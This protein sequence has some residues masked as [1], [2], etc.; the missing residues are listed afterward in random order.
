MKYLGALGIDHDAMSVL[1]YHA[2][3]VLYS[4]AY[5]RQNAIAL[6]QDWP[7]IPP[8]A[9]KTA[10]IRSS[11][12]GE[13]LVALLDEDNSVPN[14]TAGH[15][16]TEISAIAPIFREGCGP[17]NPDAGE[18]DITAGWGHFANSGAVMPGKGKVVEREFSVTERQA[19][20]DGCS[21]FGLSAEQA[22]NLLG[23][24]TFD[25]YL[26]NV[27]YWKNIPSRVWAYTI[28]GYQVI[29]KW[30]SYREREIL[31][32]GLTMEEARVVTD[33]ARRIAAILLMEPALDANYEG[34]KKAT[35]NWTA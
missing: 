6:R 14:I 8:P 15:L 26:N 28:G 30:L 21:Q 4:P 20:T 7:R 13:A 33:I 24:R 3:S 16:R 12:L 31:G 32:R 1:F 29:K 22:L 18:L 17:I 10:L 11:E 19:I 9:S 34:I 27:A 23:D 35:Y 5:R 2:V 25:V